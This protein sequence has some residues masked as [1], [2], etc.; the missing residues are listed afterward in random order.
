MPKNK[1]Q[2]SIIIPNKI[3]VF[4]DA[5]TKVKTAAFPIIFPDGK[6]GIVSITKLSKLAWT[7]SDD[8]QSVELIWTKQ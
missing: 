2:E 1:E 3:S 5:K 8:I 7:P 4:E 6:N